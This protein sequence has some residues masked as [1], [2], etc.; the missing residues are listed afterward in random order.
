[1]NHPND[2]LR[3]LIQGARQSLEAEMAVTGATG[4]RR[5]TSGRSSHAS[6]GR[7]PCS[8]VCR[9][10]PKLPDAAEKYVKPSREI[11]VARVSGAGLARAPSSVMPGGVTLDREVVG[12]NEKV[13]SRDGI[14]P[15]TMRL[16]RAVASMGAIQ[17]NG[18]VGGAACGTT[19]RHGT[20]PPAAPH[21]HRGGPRRIVRGCGK[22]GAKQTGATSPDGGEAL[23]EAVQ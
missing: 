16:A 11:I 14:T 5:H 19:S 15:V 6:S 3:A 12:E 10:T 4:E 22:S 17:V 2:F 9:N 7:S 21:Q 13:D 8:L 23:A 18:L 20:T 1:M